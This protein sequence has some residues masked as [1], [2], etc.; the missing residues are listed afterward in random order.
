M[1]ATIRTITEIENWE[2]GKCEYCDEIPQEQNATHVLSIRNIETNRLISRGCLCLECKE[3][4]E[5]EQ[6]RECNKCERVIKRGERSW[7]SCI[8]ENE[9]EEEKQKIEPERYTTQLEKQIHELN[10]DKQNLEVA[11]ETSFEAIK[12]AE[13]WGKSKNEKDL[14]EENKELK[15]K[16]TEL[17]QE[18]QTLKIKISETTL[19]DD[20]IL[21]TQ[22]EIPPKK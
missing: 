6:F 10:L 7:T 21:T 22:I 3:K 12:T 19:G 5:N 16:I 18:N 8:C 11:V 4:V 9:T 2:R 17:E 20:K 15:K 13:I 1:K 14:I